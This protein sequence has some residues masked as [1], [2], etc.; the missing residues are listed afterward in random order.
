MC[1]LSDLIE[2]R[3]IE[4][5]IAKGTANAEQSAAL[6]MLKDGVKPEKIITYFSTLTLT[7]VEKLA[8]QL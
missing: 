2:E 7:D 8:A 3:G 1:N 5:G 4:K 6:Q